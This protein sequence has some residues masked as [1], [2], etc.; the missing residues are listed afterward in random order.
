[1]NFSICGDNSHPTVLKQMNNDRDRF[2]IVLACRSHRAEEVG[3]NV[4]AR[5][6]LFYWPDIAAALHFIYDERGPA[7]FRRRDNIRTRIANRRVVSARC[8]R[9]NLVAGSSHQH[10]QINS[11]P[12]PERSARGAI[13]APALQG[14]PIG[15]AQCALQANACR[16]PMA[17]FLAA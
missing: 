1:M 8:G 15:P 9:N 3:E 13:G 17:I 2:E 7:L 10:E 4:S 14:D 6:L 5:S 16:V 12:H 11:H